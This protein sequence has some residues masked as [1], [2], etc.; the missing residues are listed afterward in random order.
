MN[1]ETEIND[2]IAAHKRDG[3][4]TFCGTVEVLSLDAD[5]ER[6]DRFVGYADNGKQDDF[7]RVVEGA[8]YDCAAD[9]L[10][11]VCLYIEIVPNKLLN[12]YLDGNA[13]P[14]GDYDREYVDLASVPAGDPRYRF[15]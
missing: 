5:G 8:R 14:Y 11:G 3:H 15:A 12:M 1:I 13:D 6:D 9:G 4:T 2:A 7:D 10:I